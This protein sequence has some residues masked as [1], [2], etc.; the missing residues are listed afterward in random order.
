[1]PEADPALAAL[2]LWPDTVTAFYA[3]RACA[4]RAESTRKTWGYTYRWIQRLHPGKPIGGFST[5]DLVAFVTQRGWDGPRWASSTARNYRTALQ[6]LFGWPHH[7]SR[8]DTD[9]AWRLGH[10]VRIRRVRVWQPHWLTEPQIAALLRTTSGDDLL[11]MRDRAALMLGLFA[12]LRTGEMH[13][14]RW[15]DVDL[16]HGLIEVI[17]KAAKPGSACI[18]PQLRAHLYLW[19]ATLH[20]GVDE[21]DGMP[22]LPQ[23]TRAAGRTEHVLRDP[24]RPLTIEGIRRVVHTRGEQIGLAYL[25]PHDLRRTLAGTL[26][27]RDTPIQDIRAVLRHDTIAATQIYLGENPLR[28]NRTMGAFVVPLASS[29]DD[30]LTSRSRRATSWTEGRARS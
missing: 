28:A 2:P 16:D 25:R 12:G 29:V 17:G 27:A 18:A 1:M 11:S 5:D 4:I 24:L 9:P 30:A 21:I 19:R 26:D 22:V 14:L 7:A 15:C 20:R 6:S 10:R 23:V 13:R 8:I 3:D